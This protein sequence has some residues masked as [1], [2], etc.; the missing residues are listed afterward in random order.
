MQFCAINTIWIHEWRKRILSLSAMS[1][2]SLQLSWQF[3]IYVLFQETTS[4]YF[5]IFICVFN[6]PE[7]VRA[8]TSIFLPFV[9]LHP[10]H[11]PE[12]SCLCSIG[13]FPHG[14]RLPEVQEGPFGVWELRC[15]VRQVFSRCAGCWD[16]GEEGEARHRNPHLSI[17]KD[18]WN[19]AILQQRNIWSKWK[20]QS[21][22][23]IWENA[24]VY[25]CRY[26]FRLGAL[27]SC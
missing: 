11:N 12:R 14:V 10:R 8:K 17:Q 25:G 9:P 4:T 6:I 27:D 3:C 26:V 20:T 13:P 22:E 23:L 24:A 5:H 15:V 7:I 2:I 1:M 21:V 18:Q 16:K 19:Y